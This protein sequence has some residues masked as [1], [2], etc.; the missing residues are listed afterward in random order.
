MQ[1]VEINAAA[2]WLCLAVLVVG[3]IIDQK[4]KL[5]LGI[6]CF[7]GAFLIGERMLGLRSNAI[8]GYF[9]SALVVTIILAMTFFGFINKSGAT[10]YLGKKLLKPLK[11]KMAL[12]PFIC[13]VISVICYMFFNA[14]AVNAAIVPL[15]VLAGLKNRVKLPVIIFSCY[16]GQLVGTQNPF[17][18]VGAA[19][20]IGYLTNYGIKDPAKASLGMWICAIITLVALLVVMYIVYR[21]WKKGPE[22]AEFKDVEIDDSVQEMTPELKK[23]VIILVVSVILLVVPTLWNTLFPSKLASTLASIFDLYN[24]FTLGI[25]ACL[26][27]KVG[28]FRTAVKSIPMEIII[29]I[30]G[31]TTLAQVATQGGMVTVLQSITSSVPDWLMVPAFW[32]MCA[33]LSFFVSGAAVVPAMWPI[34]IALA[35]TPTQFIQLLFALYFGIAISGISPISTSGVY[36][37]SMGIPESLRQEST[38]EQFKI[39]II[40][41]IIGAIL[42]LIGTTAVAGL[43]GDAGAVIPK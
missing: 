28:D 4:F 17:F 13:F 7:L 14:M 29:L 10:E 42:I 6:F 41:P 36:M 9:P 8:L 11:G 30:A 24:V 16:L 12:Y 25:L 21:G 38:K 20:R 26:I 19:N 40:M 31:V 35:N 32:I 3:V 33:A 27:L 39:A 5:P 22:R 2:L 15:L 37:L 43:F 1:A 34:I 23:S 18:G